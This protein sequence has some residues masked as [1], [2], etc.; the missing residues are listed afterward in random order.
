MRIKVWK[1]G[2]P[3]NPSTRNYYYQFFQRKKRYR[4]IL[5]VRNAEQARGAAEQIWIDEWNK[6]KEPER[7]EP[8][9]ARLFS[10]FAIKTY[11][12]WSKSHKASYEDD[13]RITTMLTDFFKDKTLAEIEPAMVELFK[14]ERLKPGKAQVTINRELSVLSKI[15]P[16]AIR[17]EEAESN[18]CQNV[19]RF[20]LD[21][22]RVRYLSED[23][24]A[25]LFDAM[26]NDKLLKSVVTVALH[27]GMRRGEIFGL[28][29]FDVD[30]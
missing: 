20:A 28:K 19:E 26:G 14:S 5:D 4:G 10:E 2:E 15:F 24:E 23:E 6:E 9:P 16:V 3:G 18:P 22:Q 27:T 12:P 29:W 30:F 8:K 13:V 7:V 11:L 17:L 25:R 1:P 21:N